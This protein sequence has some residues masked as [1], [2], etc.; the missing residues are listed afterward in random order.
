[1]RYLTPCIAIWTCLASAPALAQIHQHGAAAA[2]P[3]WSVAI[4]AQAFLSANL[5]IREFTDFYQ[6]ESPNWFMAEARRGTGPHR[7]AFTLMAS[8]EPFTLRRLGSAQVF[9]TGETLD[10]APLIDYQHPHDL[11]VGLEAAYGWAAADR[12]QLRVRG[13]PVGEATLGP[14]AVMHRASAAG[15]PTIPLSHHQ[16]D[17]THISRSVFA[18]GVTHRALTFEAS[19]FKGRE[20]DEDR[21]DLDLGAPDSWAARVSFASGAWSGQ[22]SG[23]H[24]RQPEPNEPFDVD[25]FTA[26]MAYHRRAWDGDLDLTVAAGRNHE[27]YGNNDALLIEGAWQRSQHAVHVRVESAEKNILTA[28]GLH[29]PGFTHP[30]ITSRVGAA[31]LGYAHTMARTRAGRFNLG[32]DATMHAVPRNLRDSYGTRPFSVHLYLHWTLGR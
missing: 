18:I 21:L 16:L 28:G 2:G 29:P 27:F 8:L 19:A 31:T 3:G 30:H 12:T 4:D 1:V 5:Q 25:R 15:N 13:G 17:S 10:G 23:G 22:I 24:L 32:G 9:Q 20:P 11:I 6:V 26:S 14:P 7:L